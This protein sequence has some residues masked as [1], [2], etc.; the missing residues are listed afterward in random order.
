MAGS[1]AIQARGAPKR[2]PPNERPV[3]CEVLTEEDLMEA[4]TDAGDDG[5]DEVLEPP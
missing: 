3:P 1:S 4:E 2:P 5:D